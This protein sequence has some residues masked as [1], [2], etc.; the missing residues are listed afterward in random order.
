MEVVKS[1]EASLKGAF[2]LRW[3]AD[4]GKLGVSDAEVEAANEYAL[5]T[6]TL[7]GAPHLKAEHYPV[8]DCAAKCGAKGTREISVDGH[9]E[10]MAAVQ[11]FIRGRS[12]RRSTCRARR[13]WRRSRPPT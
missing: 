1:V 4:W 7:E 2:H 10:M 3:L 11:P 9:I 13:R 8:F 6:S 12:R 5:G